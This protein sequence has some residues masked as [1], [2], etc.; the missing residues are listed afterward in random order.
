MNSI[1]N[2]KSKSMRTWKAIQEVI[3]ILSTGLAWLYQELSAWVTGG[4]T[5][6]P[7]LYTAEYTREA[8]AMKLLFHCMTL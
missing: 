1:Y 8:R 2:M 4:A 3:G 6:Y 7:E 5:S